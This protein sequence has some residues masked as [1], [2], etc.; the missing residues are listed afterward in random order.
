MAWSGSDILRECYAADTSIDDAVR[1]RVR[2]A[3]YLARRGR[4]DQAEEVLAELCRS[5]MLKPEYEREWT[6]SVGVTKLQRMLRND[7]LDLAQRIYEKLRALEPPHRDDC[8]ALGVLEIDLFVRQHS[9]DKA[10]RIVETLAR[11]SDPE[12]R[13]VMYHIQLL[14]LKARILMKAGRP[15]EGISI[16]AH[17]ASRA[18]R[19][20]LLPC[21][22]DACVTLADILMR[23]HDLRGAARLLEAIVPQTLACLDTDLAARTY[24]SLADA[25]MG[26]AGVEAEA[27]AKRVARLEQ[28]YE[29]LVPALTEYKKLE[30]LN[31]QLE[32]LSK[33]SMVMHLRGDFELAN[34][35]AAEYATTRNRYKTPN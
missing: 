28:A 7:N 2:M 24:C 30:D 10:L 35:T 23:M 34:G 15:Y 11:R 1:A 25:H 31:G 20:R 21:L 27:S 14:N 13:D 6:F 9:Y 17:A 3:Y 22:F 16:T 33:K 29:Y 18:Y 5:R 12:N 32:I 26:L 4:Y 8:I 19:A